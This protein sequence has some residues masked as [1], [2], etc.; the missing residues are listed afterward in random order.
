MFTQPRQICLLLEEDTYNALAT[1]LLAEHR[2]RQPNAKLADL[3]RH[4]LDQ[5]I[6]Q[7]RRGD[8]A[9]KGAIERERQHRQPSCGG[10]R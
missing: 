5:A 10:W 4:L 1:E 7:H 9:R 3:L 2:K 6:R 8:P